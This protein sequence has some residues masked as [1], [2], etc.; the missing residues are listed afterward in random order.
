M[1]SKYYTRPLCDEIFYISLY[2]VNACFDWIEVHQNIS[3]QLLFNDFE[4]QYFYTFL[5]LGI[6]C[7]KIQ[8][9][10]RDR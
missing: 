5:S 2:K 10:S 9:M 3:I 7:N 4:H 1:K 6:D 8:R